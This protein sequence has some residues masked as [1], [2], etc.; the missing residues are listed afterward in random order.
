MIIIAD[1]IKPVLREACEDLRFEK[2][3]I[4]FETFNREGVNDL[5]PIF[6]FE[7]INASRAWRK[8]KQSAPDDSGST[9]PKARRV[10]DSGIKN[11]TFMGK[12]CQYRFSKEIPS[13]VANELFE[14]GFLKEN[15]LPWSPGGKRYFIS[16]TP[17]HK[18]SK[19]FHAPVQLTNGWWVETHAGV[20]RNIEL[21]EKL[22]K[23]CGIKDYKITIE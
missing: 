10:P 14:K 7:P 15:L 23:Y 9:K 21:S 18:D 16:K 12:T 2:H 8:G 13:F 3:F 4:S 22:M 20:E 17:I 5:V 6:H 19:K 11:I 1:E